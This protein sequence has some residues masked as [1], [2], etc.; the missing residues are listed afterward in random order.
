MGA[1]A[2][3]AGYAYLK[4]ANEWEQV[5][6]TIAS[7]R[8]RFHDRAIATFTV[9]DERGTAEQS[10]LDD[11][12][13]FE[14]KRGRFRREFRLGKV[15]GRRD[16]NAFEYDEEAME[17]YLGKEGIKHVGL[18][19][20]HVKLFGKN[21]MIT[22]TRADIERVFAA[23]RQSQRNPDPMI[24]GDVGFELKAEQ[25]GCTV[26]RAGTCNM[27]FKEI[28]LPDSENIVMHLKK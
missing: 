10:F 19:E 2:L 21:G 12:F 25:W 13:T 1:T 9:T 17:K 14:I 7:D 23:L 20:T 22:M 28:E 18:S 15:E 24:V 8:G 3:A 11:G 16:G 27:H 4:P 26:C 6:Q 5:T